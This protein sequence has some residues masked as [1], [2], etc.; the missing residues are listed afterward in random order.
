MAQSIGKSGIA[1]AAANAGY[2]APAMA[3]GTGNFD[4]DATESSTAPKFG[5][6]LSKLQNQF[7]AKAEKPREIKKTLGKD[8]FL[9]IMI[10]QMSHQ[11]PTSPFK[12]EQM[13]QEMAQ[14]TSVEQLQNMNQ[15]LSKLS[16][17]EQPMERLAMTGLIGKTVT[18]DRGRF[19]HAEGT[20]E[21]L[22]FALPKPAA[23]VRVAIVSESGEVV[24]E[25]DIG[26]QKAG[27]GTFAWDGMKSNGMAAKTGNF[28]FRIEAKDDRGATIQTSSQRKARIVGVSFEGAEP[29]FLV[30]DGAQ[31]EKITMRNL[32]RI[33]ETFNAGNAGKPELASASPEARDAI[34]QAAS[35]RGPAG[36]GPAKAAAAGNSP[37]GIA[38]DLAEKNAEKGFPNGLHDQ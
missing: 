22:N 38:P 30:G 9:K 3:T 32:V 19:P 16:T 4:K 21:S 10:T 6:V 27:D 14:F 2:A 15:S 34:A 7:G 11:D 24:L 36:A 37:A 28:M 18:V 29:V 25:K 35:Q 33:D 31:Q 12:A 17:R 20:G 13:A 23:S 1:E 26:A 5:D 8:D